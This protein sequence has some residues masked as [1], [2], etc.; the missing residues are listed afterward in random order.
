MYRTLIAVIFLVLATV[1]VL[2]AQAQ[3][4][5]VIGINCDVAGDKP[6]EVGAQA[7][8]IDAITKSGGIPVLLPPMSEADLK[9]VMPGLD[10]VFMIGGDDYPPEMYGQKPDPSVV[11]MIK[12]RSD[13]D[14]LL[15]KNVLADKTMPFLGVCAGCQAL[16]IAVGGNLTQDIPSQKPQS[17]IKHAS[18]HGWQKG[19]NTHKVTFAKGSRLE[20]CL[21]ADAL[22]EPTSH[23]Q[24]V[25]KLGQDLKVTASSEDGLTEGIEMPERPF[26]VGVQF[27]PERAYDKN[28]ALFRQ[29]IAKAAEHRAAHKQN[30]Q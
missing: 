19:F 16:N 5:P 11:L 10:G 27:H 3:S 12:D 22:A 2:S 15:V 14:M 4:K 6:R 9:A 17:K 30:R 1:P 7:T 13:F 24:C 25:D 8:Y 26:V 28:Q 20:Q 23:H 21:G 18:K 29:F